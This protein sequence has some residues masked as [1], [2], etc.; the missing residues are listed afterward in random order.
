MNFEESNDTKIIESVLLGAEIGDL[1]TYEELSKAIGRDVRTF[2]QPS[3][4]SARQGVLVSKGIVFGVETN[5]GLRRL[6]D[7]E[8]VDSI[9]SDRA[10]VRRATRKSLKKLTV[11]KF[12]NLSEEKK[13]QHVVAS[14]Q[15]GAIELFS[16]KNATKRIASKVDAG[17]TTIA[18]GET[19]KMFS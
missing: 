16:T 8:I 15:M 18:I 17:K 19:L 4:R 14:A 3:L 6:N 12:D 11:V 1:I 2:A 10:R 13:R 5:V 7:E 9:E